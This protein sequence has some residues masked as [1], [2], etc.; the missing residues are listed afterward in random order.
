MKENTNSGDCDGYERL[1]DRFVRMLFLSEQRIDKTNTMI[2]KLVCVTE[3]ISEKY[4]THID[5]L[6]ECRTRL[7]DEVSSLTRQLIAERQRNTALVDHLIS[8]TMTGLAS[9]NAANH[10]S[11]NHT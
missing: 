9:G 8:L 11:V 6:A 2:E 10:I 5:S 7:L 3:S 1:L 4:M